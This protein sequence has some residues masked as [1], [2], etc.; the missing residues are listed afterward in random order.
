MQKI[1]KPGKD[2]KKDSDKR[3]QN[4]HFQENHRDKFVIVGFV[5]FALCSVIRDVA[6]I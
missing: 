3:Q 4:I 2:T 5:D 1:F 6:W